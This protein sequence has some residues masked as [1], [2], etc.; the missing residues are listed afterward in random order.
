MNNKDYSIFFIIIIALLWS[1]V[2]ATPSAVRHVTEFTCIGEP[3]DSHNCKDVDKPGADL[4][5]RINSTTQNVHITVERDYGSGWLHD[6]I[7]TGCNVVDY[8]NWRCMRGE[9]IA[10]EYGMS[11]GQFYYNLT[12]VTVPPNYYHSSLTGLVYWLHKW[13]DLDFRLAV[14][15]QRQGI[16]SWLIDW[17]STSAPRGR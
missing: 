7:L 5:I 10:T 4:A 1:Y 6:F 13:F 11:G 3:D 8:D 17:F 16:L 9:S 12:S 2:D 15:W 14:K